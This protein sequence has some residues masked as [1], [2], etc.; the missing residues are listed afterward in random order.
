MILQFNIIIMH[1]HVQVVDAWF[2]KV[3]RFLQDI[4]IADQEDL[5][6]CLWNCDE[7]GFCTVTASCIVLARRGFKGGA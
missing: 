2:E 7:T 3:E 4:G 6:S 1:M 5:A